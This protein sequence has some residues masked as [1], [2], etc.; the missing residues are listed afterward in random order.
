MIKS[1]LLYILNSPVLFFGTFFLFRAVLWGA[2]EHLWSARSVAYRKV[3]ARDFAAQLFHV[4][5]II[6]LVIILSDH[7]FAAYPQPAPLGHVPMVLRILLYL[8]LG[9]LGYYWMHRLMHTDS[10]WR[11][12]KW[13]HSPTYMYW[14]AGCRSTIGQQFLVGVPY[15]LAAPVLN[16]APWWIYTGLVIFS[17][18]NVDWMHLNTPW[19]NRRVEWIFVTPRFHHIHHSA[20]AAHHSKNLGNLFTIWDR[21][22]GTYLDPDTLTA[23]EKDLSFGLGEPA[24]PVRMIVGY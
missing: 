14:L 16:P 5:L 8:A 9:D 7:L 15:I 18:L 2:A 10:L 17:Y 12:H 3:A 22:F 4:F 19:G 24:N 20:D 23:K 13:H 1:T 6:P 11:V 21:L